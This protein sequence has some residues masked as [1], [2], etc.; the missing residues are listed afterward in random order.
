MKSLKLVSLVLAVLLTL[1]LVVSCSNSGNENSDQPAG[2]S[3]T[4]QPSGEDSVPAESSEEVSRG[5]LDHL[6]DLA[7]NGLTI[8]FLVENG[9]LGYPSV[10]IM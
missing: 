7:L 3:N 8:T 9:A 5:P 2:E 10:E 1:T 4:E 6:D